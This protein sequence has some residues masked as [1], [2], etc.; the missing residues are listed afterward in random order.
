LDLSNIFQPGL[1]YVAL[2]RV[3]SF[4]DLVIT[5]FNEKA[6]EVSSES[7][8]ISNY[9]K[10]KALK[11]REALDENTESYDMVLSSHLARSMYWDI[12]DTSTVR[13]NRGNNNPF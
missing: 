3:R 9:V 1:G 6:Y 12:E 8:K 4:D 7:Q 10:V 2:S 13:Q 11:A 5:G